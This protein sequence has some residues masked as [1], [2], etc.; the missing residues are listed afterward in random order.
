MS[1]GIPMQ[2]QKSWFSKNWY[3]VVGVGCGLPALCCVIL[4]GGT[5]L[6]AASAAKSSGAYI[7]ALAMLNE[8]PEVKALVGSPVQPSMPSNTSVENVNGS[9]KV[10]MTFS[11]TG[12][13]GEG[14]VELVANKS[15][16]GAWNYSKL[17]LESKGKTVDLSR[18]DKEPPRGNT[19]PEEEDGADEEA[20]PEEDVKGGN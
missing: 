10:S 8:N 20:P 12:P 2:P 17:T 7:G 13:K 14:S 18:G 4:G 3:W 15:A 9:E 1:D 19:P 5:Y 6:F 11:V 16:T